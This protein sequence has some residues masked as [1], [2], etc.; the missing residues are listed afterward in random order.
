MELAV[1]LSVCP[2]GAKVVERIQLIKLGIS[3]LPL[4]EVSPN[5]AYK[6]IAMRDSTRLSETA[7]RWRT[8]EIHRIMDYAAQSYMP[9]SSIPLL[10]IWSQTLQPANSALVGLQSWENYCRVH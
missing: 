6:A 9:L 8:G 4:K 2:S 3:L 10:P 5:L 7:H 1:K